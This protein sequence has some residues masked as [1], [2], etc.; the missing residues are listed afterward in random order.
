MS[1]VKT[2]IDLVWGESD[3][4]YPADYPR[5][6]EAELPAVRVTTIPQ[7][8]HVPE[9]E[10]PAALNAVLEKILAEPPPAAKGGKS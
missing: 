1:E 5:A 7:C 3:R 10:C 4:L 6:M 8:G 2:P 9:Q